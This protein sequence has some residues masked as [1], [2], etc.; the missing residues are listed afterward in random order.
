MFFLSKTFVRK[1]KRTKIQIDGC[2]F[3]IRKK[4]KNHDV[5]R[6]SEVVLVPSNFAFSHSGFC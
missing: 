1:K 5:K 3:F 2:V 4:T 6:V